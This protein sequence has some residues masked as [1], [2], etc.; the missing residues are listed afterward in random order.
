MINKIKQNNMEPAYEYKLLDWIDPEKLDWCM[1]SGNPNAISLL[2]K[3]LEELDWSL[4]SRNPNAIH[5]LEKN[6]DKVSWSELSTNPNAIW[7]LE[8][9]VD[10][11]SW[12]WLIDNPGNVLTLFENEDR[13]DWYL[14]NLSEKE[15]D[16]DRTERMDLMDCFNPYAMS[17][18]ENNPHE[19]D[20]DSLS[21]NSSAMLLLEKNMDRISWEGVSG[22]PSAISLRKRNMDK[23]DWS[24]LSENPNIFEKNINYSFLKE[25][26]DIVREELMMKCM[27]PLRLERW[28]EMGGD[29]DDF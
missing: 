28:L 19:V 14:F 6:L 13:I 17:F 25:R 21:R 8:K 9:N 5:L 23:I 20:W 3:N 11:I 26:M 10:K 18:L 16:M 22:N 4:L 29:I 2:E 12:Y 15:K 24:S 1:L 7:L 27:H